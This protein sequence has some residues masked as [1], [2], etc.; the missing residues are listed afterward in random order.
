VRGKENKMAKEITLI[1]DKCIPVTVDK[2]EFETIKNIVRRTNSTEN[3]K[4]LNQIINN[5]IAIGYNPA[6]ATTLCLLAQSYL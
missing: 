4:N 2:N 5:L 6:R 3:Q 1:M